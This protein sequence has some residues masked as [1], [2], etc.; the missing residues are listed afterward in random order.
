VANRLSQVVLIQ[1]G[2]AG[3]TPLALIAPIH[4]AYCVRHYID[5]VILRRELGEHGLYATVKPEAMARYAER[6]YEQIICLD[7]DCL[8]VN[9]DVDLRDACRPGKIS[10]TWHDTDPDWIRHDPRL[11]KG[12]YHAGA[13]YAG[14]SE[15]VQSFLMEWALTD[16]DDYVWGEQSTFSLILEED[17]PT[18]GR[19]I[20]H[21]W[22]AVYNHPSDTPIV[23]AWHG[24][25][26]GCTDRIPRVHRE[27][28]NEAQKF[29]LF[30]R[31]QESMACR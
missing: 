28:Y 15:V 19:I 25:Y 27:M 1:F 30:E 3:Y 22:N 29:G 20:G 5:Y 8:I 11:P 13:I 26:A 4:A 6:G 14:N 21:E 24:L 18:L 17:F 23:R 9:H 31:V 10:T 2:D 16:T 12:V 7:S